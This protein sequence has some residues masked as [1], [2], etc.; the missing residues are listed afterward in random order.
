MGLKDEEGG[1]TAIFEFIMPST[2]GPN[3]D[4]DAS[5]GSKKV[6]GEKERKGSYVHTYIHT[7]LRT[8]IHT[9]LILIILA[10]DDSNQGQDQGCR[11]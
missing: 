2:D 5:A 3:D 4:D 7:Y 1:G 10:H 11:R 6:A 9:Y 8:H